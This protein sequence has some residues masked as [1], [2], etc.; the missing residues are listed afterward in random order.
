MLL[1]LAAR[2]VACLLHLSV[3]N[4]PC[5]LSYADVAGC[6][7]LTLPGGF[8]LCLLQ[9]H[10]LKLALEGVEKERDFYFGKLREIELLCQEHGQENDDLVQ[11]LMEVLY[12]SDEQVGVRS[13]RLPSSEATPARSAA[14]PA[15]FFFF[16]RFL[17]F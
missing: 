6:I 1:R 8:L 3:S 4:P 7:F 11:R 16:L 13:P 10:S 15:I 14:H 12:A 2:P 17:F 5:F 9:V